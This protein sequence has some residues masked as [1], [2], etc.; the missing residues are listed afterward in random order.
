MTKHDP[1]VSLRQMRDHAAEAGALVRDKSREDLL[2]DRVLALALTQ[3]L[4]IIGE[5]ANRIPRAEQAKYTRIPWSQIIGL[6][7][8]LTHGYDR[9][10][11]DILWAILTRHLPPVIAELNRILGS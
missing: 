7:H 11:L 4:Q 1:L 10:D 3:L 2:S 5:A 8:R 6:R 9:V